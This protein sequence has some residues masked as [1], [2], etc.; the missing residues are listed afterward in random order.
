MSSAAEGAARSSVKVHVSAAAPRLRAA[1]LLL[2]LRIPPTLI[3]AL[4]AGSVSP[5]VMAPLL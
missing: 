3:A 1:L 4:A 2:L 5:V